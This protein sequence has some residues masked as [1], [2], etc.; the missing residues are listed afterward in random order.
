MKSLTA[1]AGL[2]C[3]GVAFASPASAAEAGPRARLLIN[4]LLQTGDTNGD[5]RLDPQ[6]IEA[7]RLHAFERADTDGDGAISQAEIRKAAE[8]R[9][10]RT[11]IARMMGEERLD[12]FDLNGDGAV[13]LSEFQS[14]PRPGLALVDLNADGSIDRTELDR[15]AEILAAA[16]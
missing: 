11:E 6:E 8:R 5:D 4:F 14:A 16:R 13:S 9:Q 1:M 3:V 10:R 15:I 7:L 2:L 12:Q